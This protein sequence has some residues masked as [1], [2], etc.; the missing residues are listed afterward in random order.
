MLLSDRVTFL[1]NKFISEFFFFTRHVSKYA[2][3]NENVLKEDTSAEI[4]LSFHQAQKRVHFKIRELN[5]IDVS[6]E[7]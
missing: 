4:N 6:E 3:D 1:K 7:R 5:L 2:K